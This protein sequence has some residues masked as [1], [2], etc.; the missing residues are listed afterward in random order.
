MVHSL[1]AVYVL[2]G[3]IGI[4]VFAGMKG[5]FG[6]VLGPTGGYIVAII[7]ASLFVGWYL[8][9]FG[10]T[11]VQAIIANMIGCNYHFSSWYSLVKSC[12][13][14]FHGMVRLKVECFHLFYRI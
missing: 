12:Q 10:H 8:E 4:P 3:V 11:K 9:N 6:I 13:R 2:M 14:I 7:P 1:S 5:G